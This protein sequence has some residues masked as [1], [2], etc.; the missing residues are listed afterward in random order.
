MAEVGLRSA[1]CDLMKFDKAERVQ[2]ESND[3]LG[4]D[5]V[6]DNSLRNCDSSPEEERLFI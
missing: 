6:R 3:V 2:M 1:H 5:G 4:S